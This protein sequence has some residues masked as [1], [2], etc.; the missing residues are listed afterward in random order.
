M[1]I[2]HNLEQTALSEMVL[3]Q[4]VFDGSWCKTPCASK[5]AVQDLAKMNRNVHFGARGESH[6][7]R[8]T[9]RYVAFGGSFPQLLLPSKASEG[10]RKDSHSIVSQATTS[11][12]VRQ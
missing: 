9:Q 4:Q 1:F 10:F 11:L 7:A 5:F 8:F 3:A 2:Y 12:A 6:H